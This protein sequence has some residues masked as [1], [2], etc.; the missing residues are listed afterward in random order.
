MNKGKNE[1]ERGKVLRVIRNRNLLLVE[2]IN[3]VK[4]GQKGNKERKGSY[5]TKE[6]PVHYSSCLLID[7]GSNKR[8]TTKWG[9]RANDGK[10]IRISKESGLEIIKPS[11]SFANLPPRADRDKDTP[12]EIVEKVTYQ[13]PEFYEELLSLRKEYQETKFKFDTRSH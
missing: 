13:P 3:L 5:F 4:R 12:R 6:A 1:G 11:P 10:K 2:G 9:Y 8:T 7:P